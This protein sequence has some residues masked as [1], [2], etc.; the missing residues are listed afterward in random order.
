[1]RLANVVAIYPE[2]RS[3]DVVFCDTQMP[4]A[5]VKFMLGLASSDAGD[6]DVPSV[7]KP[8]TIAN[9]ASPSRTGRQLIALID[10]VGGRSVITGFLHPDGGQVAFKQDDRKVHR[11]ASG[12]YHTIAP[13][14]S[15]EWYHPS[16]TYLRIGTG[17]H[18]NLTPV[19]VDGKWQEIA[20][21]PQ[22][23]ITLTTQKFTLSVD[24]ASG[25]LTV[26]TQGA[27]NI[28]APN[29]MHI[30]T[31]TLAV[32]GQITATQDIIA[33]FGA[34]QV[35]VLTHHHRPGGGTITGPPD[36]PS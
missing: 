2:R 33:G 24:P 14:G 17:P 36:R 10:S 18:E 29:G 20:N 12:A 7:P 5:E 16:G 26:T 22:P 23:T 3:A 11:H 35:A 28:S 6:W 32:T 27:A 9:S 21:A 19:S 15:L 25:D 31:P 1:M 34:T 13:D 30:T 4:C 8:D